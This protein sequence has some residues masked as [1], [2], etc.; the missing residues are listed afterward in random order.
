MK[1]LVHRLTWASWVFLI[2]LALSGVY[3]A[4]QQISSGTL[5]VVC[6]SGCAAGTLGQTTMAASQPVTIASNQSAL[7]VTLA[8]APTTAVTGTFWQ[9]TQP[10]SAI[11]GGVVTIGANADA[12]VGDATGTVNSHLRQI[13]KTLG[14]SVAVTLG[15]APALVN[16]VA[17]VGFVRSVPSSCTQ[18]TTFTSS[19]VGVAITAGTSITSTTTCLTVLYVNNITNSAAMFRFQDKT[20]TPIIWVGGNADFSIAPNSSV[21]FPGLAGVTLTGGATAIAGTAAALNMQ[22]SGLQ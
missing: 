1:S 14:A 10:V 16:G 17:N 19:T 13:A 4:Q 6:D 21:A 18:S 12:A 9:A 7:A 11:D 2:V 22:V 3:G 20:G 8:S 5:H 15:T